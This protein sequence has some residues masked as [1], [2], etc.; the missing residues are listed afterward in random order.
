MR[1]DEL[2]ENAMAVISAVE[3][4]T[5][6]VNRMTSI[7]LTPGCHVTVIKNDKRRPL[8]IYL[9]DTV[10]AVNKKECKGVEVEEVRQ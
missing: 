5:R 4:D 1:L 9:R 8:L 7:G 2:N 3:G 10:I 6:T